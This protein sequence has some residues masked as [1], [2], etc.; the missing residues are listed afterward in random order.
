MSVCPHCGLPSDL[1]TS[2]RELR[3]AVAGALRVMTSHPD[4]DALVDAY[5]NEMARI[6]ITDGFGVRADAAIAAAVKESR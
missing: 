1:L 5:V 2:C 3:D 6:G 4:V